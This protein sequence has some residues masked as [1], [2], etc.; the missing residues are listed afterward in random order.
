TGDAGPRL[1]FELVYPPRTAA[2]FPPTARNLRRRRDPPATGV[3]LAP[4]C[5]RADHPARQG[6]DPGRR[7]ARAPP[8]PSRQGVPPRAVRPGGVTPGVVEPRAAQPVLPQPGLR[9]GGRHPAPRVS[10][11][12]PPPARQGAVAGKRAPRAGSLRDRVRR[13]ESFHPILQTPG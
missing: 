9:R 7:R 2:D 13:P 5:G 4:F 10:D 12:A 6:T 1:V 8:G 3:A 11:P